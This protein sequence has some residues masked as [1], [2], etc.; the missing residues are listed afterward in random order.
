MVWV[1]VLKFIWISERPGVTPVLVPLSSRTSLHHFSKEASLRYYSPKHHHRE[2]FPLMRRS[3]VPEQQTPRLCRPAG[4]LRRAR[5]L[6]AAHDE[7]SF[8]RWIMSSTLLITCCCEVLS[9]FGLENTSPA[10]FVLFEGNTH[11]R[12]LTLHNTSV[13]F[14][15]EHF[16]VFV[17]LVS[18]GFLLL[19][20]EITPLY[21]KWT[22][23]KLLS[24]RNFTT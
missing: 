20:N 3:R 13:G 2:V 14:H 11:K 1:P 22:D 19:K 18:G 5:T 12:S 21:S 24:C 10:P 8:A 17:I 7:G 4:A 16:T 15:A 9:S 23:F 6:E